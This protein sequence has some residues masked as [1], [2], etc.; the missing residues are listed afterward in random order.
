MW[1]CGRS[2]RKQ[3]IADANFEILFLWKHR[4]VEQRKSTLEVRQSNI[5]AQQLYEKHGFESCGLRKNFYR[6][7][8]EHAIVMCS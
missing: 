1:L 4:S 5:P 2:V 8:T 7:P 3:G 6:K